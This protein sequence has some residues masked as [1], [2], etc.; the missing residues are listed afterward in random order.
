MLSRAARSQVCAVAITNAP[1][2]Y[3][4]LMGSSSPSGVRSK[5]H[6]SATSGRAPQ[7]RAAPR[8]WGCWARRRHS[9]GPQWRFPGNWRPACCCTA[10]SSCPGPSATA[11]AATA[12]PVV[13]KYQTEVRWA[14][15]CHC[16][17]TGAVTQHLARLAC[18]ARQAPHRLADAKA[19][20]CQCRSCH[21]VAALHDTQIHLRLRCWLLLVL[22]CGGCRRSRCGRLLSR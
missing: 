6:L 9:R 8:S 2:G 11:A 21:L 18:H 10:A 16:K 13:T 15:E 12:G 3:A 4:D 7:V 5:I 14:K 1:S 22:L 20:R 17:G 19:S